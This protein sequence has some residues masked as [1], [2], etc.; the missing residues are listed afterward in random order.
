MAAGHRG[1]PG[2]HHHRPALLEVHLGRALQQVLR[3][4]ERD[5]GARGRARRH[6]EHAARRVRARARPG[7]E[8][9]GRPVRARRPARSCGRARRRGRPASARPGTGSS[10]SSRMVSRAARDTTRS[11][12]AAG[13]EQRAQHRCGV[14]RAGRPGDAD[15]PRVAASDSALRRHQVGEREHEQRDADEPVGGEERPVHPGQVGGLDD[16]VLVGERDRGEQQTRPTTASRG[17]PARRTRRTARTSPRAP[18]WTVRARTGRRT[19]PAR[20][21]R[22]SA[23][24][25]RRPGRRR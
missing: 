15:D 12:G 18:P 4:A 16:R 21:A 5:A 13:V 2:H 11:T 10:V 14:R 7:G 1:L 17:R 9:A 20:C 22:R 19:A 23:G 24:R 25:P 8:V 3:Q 6:H